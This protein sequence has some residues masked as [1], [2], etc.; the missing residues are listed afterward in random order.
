MAQETDSV[1][2]GSKATVAGTSRDVVDEPYSSTHIHM[3]PLPNTVTSSYKG[4]QP[5]QTA[6]FAGPIQNLGTTDSFTGGGQPPDTQDAQGAQNDPAATSIASSPEN[7]TEDSLCRSCA[8]H[9]CSCCCNTF[10]LSCGAAL[11][12][13]AGTCVCAKVSVIESA[14]TVAYVLGCPCRTITEVRDELQSSDESS[15]HHWP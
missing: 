12:V 7:N 2:P 11:W 8:K 13:V 4:M 1:R 9:T 15:Q 10:C 5:S 3:L 14:K 6:G